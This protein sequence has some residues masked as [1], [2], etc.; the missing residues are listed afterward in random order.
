M[1]EQPLEADHARL[2]RESGEDQEVFAELLRRFHQPPE[3]HPERADDDER[4]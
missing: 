3:G 4:G 1:S 2:W